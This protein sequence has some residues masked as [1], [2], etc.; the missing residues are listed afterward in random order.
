MTSMPGSKGTLPDILIPT[1]ISGGRSAMSRT[2]VDVDDDAL[3]RAQRALGTS[4]KKDTINQALALAA[5][6]TELRRA[7]ALRWLQ[8]NAE[9]IF[10]FEFFEAQ[11][12][13]G[14]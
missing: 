12:R 14:S 5:G 6:T 7:E 3:A 9:D 4:T 13:R 2:I 11:E 8:D 1:E 10:D